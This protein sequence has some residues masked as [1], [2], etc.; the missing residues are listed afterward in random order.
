MA[1][2]HIGCFPHNFKDDKIPS[3]QTTSGKITLSGNNEQEIWNSHSLL[4]CGSCYLSIF[5]HHFVH[6][7]SKPTSIKQ[8]SYPANK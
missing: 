3:N 8:Q 1:L 5:Q 4:Y 2:S 7:K 6:S